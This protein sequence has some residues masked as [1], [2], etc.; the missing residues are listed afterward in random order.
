[1][2]QGI[3]IHDQDELGKYGVHTISLGDTLVIDASGLNPA[4]WKPGIPITITRV[5]LGVSATVTAAN[6]NY[7]TLS[8]TDGTNTIAT[9]ANGPAATGVTIAAGA[10][11]MWTLDAD[12]VDVAAGTT[13]EIDIAATGNGLA[14]LGAVIQIEYIVNL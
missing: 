10:F 6:T 13:L 3:K 12:H 5:L 9:M 2:A 1:M 7:Q 4:I 14:W 8:L 11:G